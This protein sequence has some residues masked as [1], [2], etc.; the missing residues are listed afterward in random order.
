MT[1]LPRHRVL[2]RPAHLAPLLIALMVM[3]SVVGAGLAA[4]AAIPEVPPSNQ[5]PGSKVEIGEDGEPGG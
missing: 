3:A 2:R 5:A 1:S 4:A